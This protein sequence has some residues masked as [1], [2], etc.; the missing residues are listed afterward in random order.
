MVRFLYIEWN[1]CIYLLKMMMLLLQTDQEESRV[2]GNGV[3]VRSGRNI[4]SVLKIKMKRLSSQNW[5]GR[6][7][8]CPV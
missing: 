3:Y 2:Q 7:F 6:V 5:M 8:K 4:D 1:L